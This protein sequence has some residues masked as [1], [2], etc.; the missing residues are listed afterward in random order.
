M[1]Y[2]KNI[3]F[4]NLVNSYQLKFKKSSAKKEASAFPSC[5]R[6]LELHIR[7]TIYIAQLWCNSNLKL[8]TCIDPEDYGWKQIDNKYVFHWFDGEECPT[9]VVDVVNVADNAELD[10]AR[11]EEDDLGINHFYNL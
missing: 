7:G 8:P 9:K 6:E 10:E 3:I 2:W 11:D 4:L 1:E 5:Y